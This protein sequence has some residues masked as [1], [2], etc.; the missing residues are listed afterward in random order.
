MDD[1]M[2]IDEIFPPTEISIA[3]DSIPLPSKNQ[4]G[5]EVKKWCRPHELCN[6][7]TL[8]G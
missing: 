3:T 1:G 4:S 8:F 5:L 6:K 7:P 2:Y